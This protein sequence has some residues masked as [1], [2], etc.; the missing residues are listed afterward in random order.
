MKK[1]FTWN[2]NFE[3]GNTEIDKQHKNFFG[4]VDI[5]TNNIDHASAFAVISPKHKVEILKIVIDLKQ[6]AVYHF[7]TEER[8]LLKKRYSGIIAHKKLHN[9]F[10]RK[11]LDFEDALFD[12]ELTVSIKLRDF[13]SKWWA[14]HILTQDI[15]YAKELKLGYALQSQ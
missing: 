4:L 14:D 6:Y 1:K 5:L 10:L 7:Q 2:S 15:K 11:V 3:T 13:L 12:G 9:D 8:I